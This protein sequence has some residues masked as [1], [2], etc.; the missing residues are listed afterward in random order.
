MSAGWWGAFTGDFLIPF[1]IGYI[2]LRIAGTK[3]DK[4]GLRTQAIIW[5]VILVGLESYSQKAIP[6]G[7]VFAVAV[8]AIWSVIAQSKARSR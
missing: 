7:G 4:E 8:C 5:P 2:M 1:A 6:P 3:P